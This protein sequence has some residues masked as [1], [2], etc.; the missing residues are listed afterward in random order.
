M[1][2]QY[3]NPTIIVT[4]NGISANRATNLVDVVTAAVDSGPYATRQNFLDA[5]VL[6]EV[7]RVSFFVRDRTYAVVR[8]AAGTIVQTNGEKW[9]PD[10]DVTPEHFGAIGDGVA[11][12][13]DELQAFLDACKGGYGRFGSYIYRIN[14]ELTLPSNAVIEGVMG[15]DAGTYGT[16][17]RQYGSKLFV[18]E[19]ITRLTISGFMAR[20]FKSSPN[21]WDCLFSIGAHLGCTFSNIRTVA[22]DA[23]TIFERFPTAAATM[24]TIFNTYKNFYVSACTTFCVSAGKEAYYYMHQGDGVA[25]AIN[26]ATV[27][28]EQNTGSVMVLKETASR[29]ASELVYGTDYTVSYD[30]SNIL[31]VTLT[32]AATAL[33]RIHIW[34]RQPVASGNRRPISNN[35]WENN[36]VEYLFSR[37]HQSYRWVDAETH[38]DETFIANANGTKIYTTNPYTNRTGEGGDFGSYLDCTLSYTSAVTDVTTLRGFD[39]GPGSNCMSGRGIRMDLLWRISSTNYAMTTRSGQ[40]VLLAG[41]VSG[42]IGTAVVTGSG[43]DFKRYLTLIGATKD[44]VEIDGKFYAIASIDS[45]TQI[46]LS[47]NLTTSPSGSAISRIA[48]NSET[49]A[50]MAF[51]SIG[52]GYFQDNAT[53]VGRVL[54]NSNSERGGTATILSGATSVVVK[55]GLRR[56]PVPGEVIATPFSDIGA[57]SFSISAYTGGTSFQINIS[58]AAAAD[59]TFGWSAKLFDMN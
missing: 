54:V 47:A 11:D 39:F 4:A 51:A 25:T 13:T 22:Y 28:P 55:H 12:D 5:S 10:G 9:K 15:D 48:I 35:V 58:S 46:T 52:K 27:W 21:G 44:Q 29:V 45:A 3:V 41:T 23:C 50:D 8:D 38:K 59:Y 17:L 31:T 14:G 2:V 18:G 26:T 1:T 57:R 19:N 53:Q 20:R 56:A 49:A 33:E 34:P 40:R 7:T 24:N 43:T 42:T 30:G 36:R 16:R 6:P 32:V 37:G